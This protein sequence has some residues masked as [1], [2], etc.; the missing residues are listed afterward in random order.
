ML[1][2]KIELYNHKNLTDITVINFANMSG[3]GQDNGM[4]HFGAF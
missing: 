3:L 2:I 1:R 4:L